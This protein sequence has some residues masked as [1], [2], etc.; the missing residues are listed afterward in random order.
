M[1]VAWWVK[2]RGGGR[3]RGRVKGQKSGAPE[4]VGLAVTLAT[5]SLGRKRGVER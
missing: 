1:S 5:S 2:E 4:I 3:A